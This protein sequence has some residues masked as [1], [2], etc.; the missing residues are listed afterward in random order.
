MLWPLD[1]TPTARRSSTER[2]VLAGF[3]LA[4]AFLV[5][6]GAV[7]YMSILRAR[8]DAAWVTHTHDVIMSLDQLQ[9]TVTN[10]ESA[11]RG[12]VVTGNETYLEPYE[13]ALQ[14]RDAQL[15]KLTDLVMDN[16]EQRERVAQLAPLLQRRFE[17]LREVIDARRT[18]GFEAAQALVV[19]GRGKAVHDQIRTRVGE[20]ARAEETVL[21]EREARAAASSKRARLI[22]LIGGLFAVAVIGLAIHFI[23]R[24]FAGRQ[25]AEVQL[26]R[27]FS[28]SLDFLCI[29][30]ADGYFKRVSPA[31]TEILGWSVEE[32]LSR[33]FMDF[34]HPA[35]VPATTREVERQI[36][37]GEKVMHFEN[38]YRHK[39][40]SW[41]VL[42]WRSMPQPDG[43]MYATA[44]DVTELKRAELAMRDL[45]E[46]L[47]TRVSERT[48]ELAQA[49]ESL[50]NSER[51]FRALIE[52]GSDGIVL[53][54]PDNRI[55]YVSPT[56][57]TVEGY[58]PEDL[59]NR[60]GTEHTHPDD[61]PL[62]QK[63]V[64]QLV[65]NPG[66]PVPVLWRRRHKNGEWLWLEGTA[67]NLIDDPAVGAIVTNYRDVTQRKAG[68]ARLQAQLSRLA[69]LSQVTR[70]IGERQDVESIFQVVVQTLEEH[71]P[72]DFTCICLYEPA[73]A[74][75][76]VATVG[77]VS[78]SIAARLDMI[79]GSRIAI[80]ENGLSRCVRGRLVYEP[81]LSKVSFPFPRRLSQGGLGAM[82]AAP[83][84]VESQVFGVLLA[85][86][87]QASSFS[88]SEC[89]FLR[90]LSEH[91]ALAAHQA[92][93]YS[94][95]QQAYD[96]LRTT[97]QAVMQ[98]ERLM[99]L[100][101]MA[102]GIAH[103]INN[104]ISPVALY[105]ESL[106]EKEPSLSPRARGYLETIQRAIDDVAQTVAR[107]REFYRQREPQSALSSVDA[108]L[109]V[110]Q[111][112]DLTRARWSDMAQQRG[113]SIEMRSEL[114]P[115]LPPIQGSESEIRE[116]LINLIFNAVDAMP[117]GGPLTVRTRLGNGHVALEVQDMGIG[118]D[119]DTCRRC[120]EPFFTTKGER[121]TGLGLAMVYGSMQRHGAD[122]EIDSA[123]GKGTTVRLSFPVVESAPASAPAKREA[124]Q[125]PAPLRI[126]VVDDDPM[127]VKTLHDTL[128]A[129]GHKVTTAN[130]G[131]AGIDAFLAAKRNGEVFPVVI[132]DLGMPNVDGR[133]VSAAVKTASPS[134]LVLMLTGWGQRLVAEGDIPEHVDRVL[135]KPPKLRDLREALTLEVQT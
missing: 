45:N 91:V 92:Q 129:D 117:N 17:I 73:E 90:Q 6:I 13:Q 55:K 126:L 133:K 69:L 50:R 52:H 115:E 76:R 7:A 98:Q 4:L 40:G 20:M 47:E 103:D 135:N 106:L 108:N 112:T 22:I 107:M 25:R 15:Q 62:V 41:R 35:D 48:A 78:Q 86:R 49:N 27:F 63:V 34:V 53:I 9:A 104:A 23:R 119:E 36:R 80:D 21:S 114:A 57:E 11:Q 1:P 88:S 130:G 109:L 94:A 67:T 95:L 42:S 32:F 131:Q 110:K 85:A 84:L 54:D 72:V 24:D 122:I 82:V 101:Q 61:L 120:L 3:A 51:R 12:Y 74:R 102:S 30:S 123:V 8:A 26:E 46:S 99:A 89:E 31:V 18:L 116:A 14:V 113:V 111:V 127:I 81:E 125:V 68:E 29:A 39:D 96:E 5:L 87:S 33:P 93:L 77:A 79:P 60:Y 38:R 65:A 59:L 37:A 44:R 19:P 105:T 124:P 56:V 64:E 2:K 75:I 71:L 97:Q 118:M 28:L 132:T 100:G 134:T 121:G 43:L 16:A 83:L 58:K 66:K 70:A 128:T 10:A